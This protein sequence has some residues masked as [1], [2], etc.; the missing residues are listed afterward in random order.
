MK[1]ILGVLT[2]TAMLAVPAAAQT[3]VTGKWELT[4]ESPRG[5]VTQVMMLEQDGSTVVGTIEG[6]GMGR[7]RGGGGRGGGG[8]P[9][10]FDIE[11]GM[12]DGD[13]ITF[14][15]VRSFGDRSMTMEYV[16]TVDGDAITGTMSTPRGEMEF[17]AVRVETD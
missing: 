10:A 7:G 11:D 9:G 17:S 8:G 15:I 3:D 4:F 5:Q 14:V 13:T 12:I 6:G 1:R 2:V 16:G